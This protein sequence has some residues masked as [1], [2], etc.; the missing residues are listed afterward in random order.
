MMKCIIMHMIL[1]I[2]V[3]HISKI[4]IRDDIIQQHVRIIIKKIW[5]TRYEQELLWPK[6]TNIIYSEHVNF[7]SLR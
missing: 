7:N 6:I 1:V 3:Y 2:N 5:R 4:L